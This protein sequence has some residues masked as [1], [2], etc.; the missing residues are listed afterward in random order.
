MGCCK[1]KIDLCYLVQ[2]T[3]A[4]PTFN[5]KDIDVS[6]DTFIY[7]TNKLYTCLDERV[8]EVDFIDSNTVYIVDVDLP[9]SEYNHE[10]LWI[11]NGIE[12]VV[13][14]GKLTITN[15]AKDCGC[16]NNNFSFEVVNEEV[17][18]SI[19]FEEKIIE[20]IT[21]KGPAGDS[22]YQVAVE[23]GFVGTEA[24]W[25]ESL[26]G[27]KG[28]KGDVGEQGV[29]GIKG[30][31]G[32]NGWTPIHEFEADGAQRQVKK[33]TDY[34]GGTGDKPTQNIGQYVID[35]GY[36]TDKSLA[37][38]FKGAQSDNLLF[39]YV[40]S[41]NKEVVIDSYNETNGYFTATNHG[42]VNGRNGN[43]LLNEGIVENQTLI[44]FPVSLDFG[45]PITVI[46]SDTFYLGSI[47]QTPVDLDLSKFHFEELTNLSQV[48]FTGFSE[49][50]IRV[51]VLS[52]G[53]R[54]QD[55]FHEKLLSVNDI[56]LTSAPTFAKNSLS[57]NN[58]SGRIT[59]LMSNV[60][61]SATYVISNGVLNIVAEIST[62]RNDTNQLDGYLRRVIFKPTTS[63]LI[64]KFNGLSYM[65]NGATIKIYKL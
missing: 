6:L 22:A 60:N 32:F 64:T 39:E 50:S 56:N 62:Y 24:E 28:D 55:L 37:T 7:K 20:R 34:I 8:F 11:R 49:K 27:E 25:L 40:H 12:T 23:N 59:G 61:A 54:L 53:F 13:F 30:E 44:M 43:F 33:L 2:E 51:H 52:K 29:Q 16:G 19:D 63:T 36:T 42:L 47:L 15:K 14:Q 41:G 57:L 38:N 58:Q 5:F 45:Y 3:Y 35:G 21:D 10:L 9:I 26:K 4:S 46:D 48:H 31:Q 18:V 1:T 17:T 65:P